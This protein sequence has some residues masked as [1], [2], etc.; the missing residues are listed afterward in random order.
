LLRYE[1]FRRSNEEKN[2]VKIKEWSAKD[3]LSTF[4][5]KSITPGGVYFYSI[6]VYDDAGN[7]SFS[8]ERS[9]IYET[10]KRGKISDIHFTVDREKRNITLN[11]NYPEKDIFSFV[12]YKSKKGEQLRTWKTV[13]GNLNSIADKELYINNIYVYRIKAVL[14]N[15]AE[16][17]MS[18]A[19]EVNY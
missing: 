11:W 1:L 12:I 15:G 6:R 13:N 17:E 18:D 3:S 2:P 19:L 7:N 8:S 5:D 14:N 9:V 16:S 4:T 10:G